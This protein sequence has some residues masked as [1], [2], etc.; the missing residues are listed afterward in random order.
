MKLIIAIIKPFK[1]DEV[2]VALSGIGVQGL[3]VTEVKGFGR[4]KGHTELYRGAE[5]AV[6]FLPKLRVEAAVRAAEES[7]AGE[8]VVVI[9]RQASGYRA[10]PF[11]YALLGALIVPWP[12]ILWTELG[13]VRIFAV[14]LAVAILLLALGT[15]QPLRL[16]LVPGP[17]KRARAR[18][19]AQHEFA[20]R[21]LSDTRGRTGV[22]LFVSAAEHHAE[23]IGD[24]A[25][26]TR[27]PEAEWRGVIERLVASF[28]TGEPAS[29]LIEAVRAIGAIL[30][31]YAPPEAGDSDELPNRVVVL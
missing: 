31:R 20:S 4:Q 5:Y 7:T 6:D 11:L 26:S 24:V 16:R 17:I 12:M 8:I 25:I 14:Q 13:P 9:A 10:I 23:V 2:R 1:L 27:V 30:A 15:W 29:G 18:E 19:A 21:G 28:A 3:T 22:L